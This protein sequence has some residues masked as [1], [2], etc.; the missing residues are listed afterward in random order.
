[1]RLGCLL[2]YIENERI[3]SEMEGLIWA[4][5][6]CVEFS[7]E[8][9]ER[10]VSDSLHPNLVPQGVAGL[11]T[12]EDIPLLALLENEL[13]NSPVSPP[14]HCTS[15]TV[16]VEFSTELGSSNTRHTNHQLDSTLKRRI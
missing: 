4:I 7:L 12:R 13:A 2:Q 16:K 5:L 10:S 11:P 1:M 8:A 6:G 9:L 15:S 3:Q 14:S